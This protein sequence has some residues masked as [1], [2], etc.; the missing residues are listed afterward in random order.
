VLDTKTQH[1]DRLVSDIL[2]LV[3]WSILSKDITDSSFIAWERD[4]MENNT[5]LE[6]LVHAD[7]DFKMQLQE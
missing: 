1:D 5:G 4:V 3:L 7:A 2:P 6:T